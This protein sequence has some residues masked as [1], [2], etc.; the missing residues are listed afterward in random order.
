MKIELFTTDFQYILEGGTFT[1]LLLYEST[2]VLL[3]QEQLEITF[4]LTCTVQ[5]VLESQNWFILSKF[6]G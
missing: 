1:G 2:E 6:T 5:I 3:S 4:I